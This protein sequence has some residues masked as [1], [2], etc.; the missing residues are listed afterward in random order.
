VI[1]TST[2]KLC[3]GA[4]IIDGVEIGAKKSALTDALYV[5]LHREIDEFSSI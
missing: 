1:I 5:E 2:T 4:K 3:L